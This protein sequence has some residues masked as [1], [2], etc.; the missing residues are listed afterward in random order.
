MDP[1]RKYFGMTVTQIGIL[2]GMALLVLCLFGVLGYLI[3]GGGLN[4]GGKAQE[5]PTPNPTATLVAIP[6]VTPTALPTAVPYEQLIP[7]GWTQHRTALVELWLPP[8]Y[9]EPKTNNSG[10]APLA[11]SEI[12]VSRP[13][14]KASL[15]ALW[16]I[17]SYE[18][19]TTDSLDAFL[20]V[21]FTS[22]PSE[23]RVVDRRN[24]SVNSMPAVR[25][26]IESRVKNQDV[27]EL[28]YVFQDGGTVWYVVF[29]GQINDFYDNMEKFE[30][31]ARTFRLVK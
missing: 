17:V 22:L 28:V 15:Y 19:L 16:V 5:I 8:D 7:V 24:G 1:N 12:T 13:A 29:A 27:N 30:A 6:T 25:V 26:V 21:K 18:P 23:Y 4:L 9:K 2:G 20:D 14:A 3:L 31:S 11:S 10:L